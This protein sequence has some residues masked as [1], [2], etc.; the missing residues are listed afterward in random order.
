M[1]FVKAGRGYPSRRGRTV[2]RGGN[3]GI[4][5]GRDS[6][7]ESRQARTS[8][9]VPNTEI[10]KMISDVGTAMM[11]LSKSLN[12]VLPRGDHKTPK[13]RDEGKADKAPS[14]VQAG[15]PVDS[16][17]PK[18]LKKPRT[19]QSNGPDGASNKKAPKTYGSLGPSAQKGPKNLNGQSVDGKKQ[20]GQPGKNGQPNGPRGPSTKKTPVSKGPNGQSVVK[21][22]I[23]PEATKGFVN[24]KQADKTVEQSRN[25]DFAAMAKTLF[26][27]VQLRHH[28]SN[29]EQV[30]EKVATRINSLMTDIKPP[31]A[32]DRLQGELYG[33]GLEFSSRI[34]QTVQ[35]HLDRMTATIATKA[36]SLDPS[37]LE[38]ACSIATKYAT[39]RLG[40]RLTAERCKEYM[41]DAVTLV[42]VSATATHPGNV[43]TVSDNLVEPGAALAPAETPHKRKATSPLAKSPAAA[44]GT[45]NGELSSDVEPEDQQWT[46][47]S[48]RRTKKAR[49][50]GPEKV[51]RTNGVIVYTCDPDHWVIEPT[52]DKQFLLIADSNMRDA[53]NV[54]DNYEVHCMPGATL[55]R[56]AAAITRMKS[57]RRYYVRIQV[58]INNRHNTVEEIDNAVQQVGVALDEH[59]CVITAAAIGVSRALSLPVKQCSAI[60][61]INSAMRE[62]FTPEGWIPPLPLGTVLIHATD[63]YGIHHQ[64]A[65]ISAILKTLVDFDSDFFGDTA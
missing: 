19:G 6:D 43:N 54:P 49:N 56:A 47:V 44:V 26:K 34:R 25:Q 37:D 35:E 11:A 53:T 7:L 5:R 38:R 65:T 1:V 52:G 24:V 58:G 12:M 50:S 48:P 18:G 20:T 17:K 62:S 29:W 57:N 4:V 27:T 22:T 33:L 46:T 63:R 36:G 61:Y 42:G 9:A 23:K 13:S 45:R 59:P 40:R 28:L 3:R 2:G 39:Q 64:G 10:M 15:Q 32:D 55:E 51:T 31:M 21:Q 8:T 14:D 60:D 41:D 16:G 30:P